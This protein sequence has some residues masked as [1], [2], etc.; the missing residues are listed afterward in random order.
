M[1]DARLEPGASGLAYQRPYQMTHPALHLR[2]PFVYLRVSCRMRSHPEGL[3]AIAITISGADGT[4]QHS[5]GG[6]TF[7]HQVKSVRKKC[8]ANL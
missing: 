8:T 6:V 3:V 5:S 1:T 4:L 2:S 7:M